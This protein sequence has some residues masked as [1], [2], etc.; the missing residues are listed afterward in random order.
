MPQARPVQVHC[1]TAHLAILIAQIILEEVA[2]F[3]DMLA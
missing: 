2:A 3:L 1:P